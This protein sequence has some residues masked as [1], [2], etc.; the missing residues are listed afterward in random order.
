FYPA[1]LGLEPVARWPDDGVPGWVALSAGAARLMLR[2]GHPRREVDHRH[3][4]GP[5]TVNLYVEGLD[6]LR[7]DLVAAGHP[8]SKTATLFYGAREF[9]VLDPDRN[10]L[11]L[12]EFSVSDPGYMAN[13]RTKKRRR[14]R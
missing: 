3:Q 9:Y 7:R 2:V 6:A 1:L 11:A 14:R 8:C 4:P 12:V 13:A 5:V 10:E